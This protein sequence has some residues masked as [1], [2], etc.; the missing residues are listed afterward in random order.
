[1]SDETAGRF[2][3]TGW[4][5]VLHPRSDGRKYELRDE[6]GRLQEAVGLAAAIG[7]RV[8]LAEVVPLRRAHPGTLFGPGKVAEFKDR[9]AGEEG[10]LVVV[11]QPLS[12]IQQRNL[13]RA[14]KH[15]VIDR[16]GLILEIFGARAR[17]REGQLQVELAALG[18]QRSRLVRSWTHLERQRGGLGFVGGPGET[19]LEID[20][21]RIDERIERIRRDLEEVKRTR[22][23]HRAARRRDNMPTVALVGYT[24]A[25]KSTLFNRLTQAGVAAGNRLFA[26]LDPTMRAIRLPSGRRAVLSD[27]VGF[28]SNLPTTLVAAFRATLEEV[29]AADIVVHVRDI[30][31]PDSGA[32]R[33]DVREVLAQLDLPEGQPV[34]EAWNKVDAVPPE[35]LAQMR[36]LAERQADVVLLS[37][38]TGSGCDELLARLEDGL[39]RE[40]TVVEL[41]LELADGAWLAWLHDH[42]QVLEQRNDEHSMHLRVALDAAA[43]GW[44][45]AHGGAR[46][47]RPTTN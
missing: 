44:L 11:D 42:G 6:A 3:A 47:L 24:N 12:P 10:G 4:A 43:L 28:V 5:W 25:G 19:Q 18:Y 45:R 8:V 1:M 17:T 20:R 27:T 16:T 23:L 46:L 13:E 35:E 40:R 30:A 7:L 29:R 38:R 34:V 15:K 33:E 32:Q 21:R 2:D 9:L 39:A 37:A 22:G 41:H 14:W 31:H 36:P 26:T